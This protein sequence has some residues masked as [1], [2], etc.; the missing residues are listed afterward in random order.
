MIVSASYRTDVPAF[1]G[2]WFLNRLDAGYCMAVNPYGGPAYRVG[3]QRDQVDGFVFWTKNLGPF[4]DKLEIVRQ[5]GYPFVVQ[6]S[7]N[8]Y[9]RSLELS[10]GEPARSV[11]IAQQVAN[12]YGPRAVVWRYD[13][14]V[15][16]SSTSVAFH[17]RNFKNLAAALAGTTDEV[18]ISFAHLYR[19]TRRNLDRAAAAF[20]FS[21]DDPSDEA[22]RDLVAEFADVAA[23]HQMQLS[24]CSQRQYLVPGVAAARCVDAVRLSDVAGHH[25]VAPTRGNRPDCACA[26]SRDV[27]AYDTCPHGCVYCYAVSNRSVARQRQQRHDPSGAFLYEPAVGG[28]ASRTP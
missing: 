19:K 13:P 18:V 21:W 10:V 6:Y 26:A 27:G 15:V 8:G 23:G 1:Y 25:I 2:E 7:I 16:T 20:D 22:K 17:R 9:P 12:R 11:A 14:I 3:L 24:V 4:L 5:R 28:P